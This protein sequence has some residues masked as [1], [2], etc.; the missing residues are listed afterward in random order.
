M[1][2]DWVKYSAASHYSSGRFFSSYHTCYCHPLHLFVVMTCFTARQLTQCICKLWGP[3]CEVYGYTRLFSLITELAAQ[4]TVSVIR[5]NFHLVFLSNVPMSCFV[6]AAQCYLKR[7]CVAW[8]ARIVIIQLQRSNAAAEAHRHWL[9]FPWC[10][11]ASVGPVIDVSAQSP[12]HM[13]AYVS[14]VTTGPL[15]RHWAHSWWMCLG[16]FL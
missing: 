14:Q 10:V 16:V 2:F 4:S 1:T 3:F 15:S 12:F 8:S 7:L 9:A 6:T 13:W 5:L 11:R